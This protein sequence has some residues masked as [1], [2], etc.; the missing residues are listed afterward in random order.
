MSEEST[1]NVNSSW[2]SSSSESQNFETGEIWT[3]EFIL[4]EFR[5]PWQF[6]N[7]TFG[8]IDKTTKCT[9]AFGI[10]HGNESYWSWSSELQNS[11][12]KIFKTYLEIQ[13][14][15]PEDLLKFQ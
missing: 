14:L 10:Y 1:Y 5:A 3:Q 4:L 13:L 12:S 9:S 2:N 6:R 15:H 7:E 8:S 11:T